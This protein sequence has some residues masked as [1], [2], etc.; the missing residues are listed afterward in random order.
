T[1]LAV[2]DKAYEVELY[3]KGKFRSATSVSWSQPELNVKK[4]KMVGFPLSYEERQA[5]FGEDISHIFS[6]KVFEWKDLRSD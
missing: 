3:E 4:E 5:Y 1:D 6:V 2:A